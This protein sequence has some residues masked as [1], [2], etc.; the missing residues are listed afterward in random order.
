ME[1]TLYQKWSQLQKKYPSE[2]I[3]T[4]FG[5]DLQ[6]QGSTTRD[7]IA[8]VKDNIW[9]PNS[10]MDYKKLKPVLVCTNGKTTLS[11][12]FTILR[13]FI[14][15][16]K[17]NA[18]IGRR[19]NYIVIDETSGKYL[20]IITIGSDFLDMTAR[21]V[22]IGWDRNTKT[23]RGMI[24]HTAIGA[25]I[26]PTQPLGY[27]YV[28]GKLLALLCLSD[29]IQKDWLDT[30]GDVLVGVTTTSLWGT[31]KKSRLS[32]YDNLKYWKKMGYTTGSISYENEQDTMDIMLAWLLEK[33]P[34]KYFEWYSAKT[35]DGQRYKRDIRNRTRQFIYSRLG[36]DKNL[37]RS[38]H[39]RGIY[40][41]PLYRNTTDFL[42]QK[43]SA[44]DLVKAFDTEDAILAEIWR[45]KYAQHRIE[46]LVE[47]K[48]T[49]LGTLF[50]DDMIYL[51][52]QE[53]KDKYIR[54]VGR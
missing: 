2:K 50:Y 31:T 38:S 41:S 30:Y 40:F 53:T 10:P 32:Q 13:D 43:I 7:A 14:S 42:T 47:R 17:N 6:V 33:F 18:N 46:R 49:N 27:N 19:L 44:S 1:Y 34:R 3:T 36:I 22:Y 28:G 29:T 15:T 23:N 25:V 12:E 21:D 45:D 39:E 20:G 54:D 4:L 37:S 9:I 48:Q 35:K 5:D 24:N 51:T 16:Q 11:K 52:W 8:S 26:V